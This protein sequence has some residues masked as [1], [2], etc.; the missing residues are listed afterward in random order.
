MPDLSAKTALVVG[1]TG[2]IG[3]Q[4][5][6][7]L[8]Q[9]PAYAEVSVLVRNSLGIQDP[10]LKE[11]EYDFSNP[12]PELVRGDDVFCCLGTTMKKA[13]S[14]DAFRKVDL[15]YPLQI[16]RLARQ[17]GASQYLIVTAMGA[18]SDSM[19]FYN[20]VKG[21]VQEE[22]KALQFPMLRIFQPSLLLGNRQEARLGE[23][24]GEW[25]SLL[26]R[27]LMVGPLRKYQ[28]IDSA[29]VARAM[30]TLAQKPGTGVVIYDSEEL[31]KY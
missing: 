15:E 22:L 6:Q 14:K 30:V 31:Q 8:L 25:L 28:A 24:V 23:K 20:Q 9:S 13:G 29:K 1:A 21:D 2:L 5:V 16:G 7:L 11:I 4:V 3:K 17:S 27:P 18:D 26:F 12:A 10:K 19:F